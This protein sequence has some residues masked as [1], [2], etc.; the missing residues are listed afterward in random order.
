M[1]VVFL[2]LWFFTIR[3]KPAELEAAGDGALAVLLPTESGDACG[4]HGNHLIMIRTHA[5]A[6][7]NLQL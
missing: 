6:R 2:A 4:V 7:H 5:H 1:R 3:F